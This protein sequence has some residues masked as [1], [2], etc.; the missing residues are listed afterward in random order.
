MAAEFFR[1]KK[2]YDPHEVFQ[3]QFYLRYGTEGS[4]VSG[5]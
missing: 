1:L 5:E 4:P 3:N 2:K